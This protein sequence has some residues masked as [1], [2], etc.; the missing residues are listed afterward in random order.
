MYSKLAHS[1]SAILQQPIQQETIQNA[2]PLI[3]YIRRKIFADEAVNINFI[4][5]HN[6][7]RSQLAQLWA[8]VAAAHFQIGRI[9]CYSG[10]T[11]AT[12]LYPAVAQTLQRAGIF[13]STISAGDNPVYFMKNHENEPPILCFSKTFDH[14]FNPASNYVAVMTCTDADQGCPF[15]Q[16]A[17]QRV[18]IPFADPKVADHTAAQHTIYD[19]R[20]MEIAALMFFIFSKLNE[21]A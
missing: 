17:E 16:G 18:S 3:A 6:S 1:I 8:Q 13:V 11:E 10:G 7:R 5:T 15:I 12:A 20:S 14:H 4:C 2:Q 9:Y 21:K 19:A